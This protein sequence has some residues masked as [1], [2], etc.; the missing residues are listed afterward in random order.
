MNLTDKICILIS[1]IIMSILSVGAFSAETDKSLVGYWKFDEGEGRIAKD[2][3]PN[4]NNGL[5]YNAG[6]VKGKTGYALEFN[7]KDSYADCG[8]N[9]N[10]NGATDEITIECWVRL[11][12][13]NTEYYPII[14]GKGDGTSGYRL[15]QNIGTPEILFNVTDSGGNYTD[16]T[17]TYPVKPGEW[18]HIA[19]T[20]KGKDAKVYANG[21]L[22]L[23]YALKAGGVK[24]GEGN[25]TMGSAAGAW[26]KGALDEVDI[27]NKALTAEEIKAHCEK[28][29]E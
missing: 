9:A 29:N 10:M 27:Y 26:F 16:I 11:D 23:A 20:V 8:N 24:Q 6:W 14:I 18:N 5:I 4:K 3:S 28:A 22:Y 7:G 17:P 15:A 19:L 1:L 2:S 25:L 13:I 12:V 21:N